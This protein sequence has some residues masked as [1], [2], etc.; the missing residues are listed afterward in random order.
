MITKSNAKPRISALSAALSFALIAHAGTVH[1]QES[2]DPTVATS[3]PDAVDLEKVEVVGSRIKRAQIEGPAPVTVISADQIEREGFTTISQVLNTLT[4]SSGIIQTEMDAG[5]FTQNANVINLRGLGPGR[6][7]VLIDGRRATDYP[8]PFDGQSNVVNLGSIPAAAVDRVELLAGGASAIYGSDAVAGVLNIVLKKHVDG[9]D[10]NAVIGGTTEGGGASKRLQLVGGKQA[11]KLDLVYAFEY[12]DRQP[13]WGFQRRVMDSFAD[14]PTLQGSVVNTR[15][16]LLLDPFDSD[17][18]G[19]I[20]I[21][22]TPEVCDRF[23]PDL[24]HSF[25]PGRGYYCGRP[26]DASQFTIRNRDRNLSGYLNANYALDNGVE[27]FGS[28]SAWNSKGSFNTG[29]PFWTDTDFDFVINAGAD[30]ALDI[31]GIGGQTVS[32]QRIFTWD[33][34]GGLGRNNQKFDETSWNLT[35]GIRGTF[36]NDRLDYEVSYSHS[37]Y[38]LTR[39]RRLFIKERVNGYF[40]GPQIGEVEGIPVYADIPYDRLFNPMTPSV[41]DSLSEIDH[42]SA[43]SSNDIVSAVVTGDLFDLPAGPL[44]FA[45]VLEWGSQEY[46]IDLDQRLIDGEFWGFTGTGGGG[47]RDRTAVGLEFRAPL[48]DSLTASIAGRYD[49]YDDITAVDDAFTYN[50]GLEWRPIESLL[51]RGSYSTSF[52]APDMHYVFSDPSGFFTTVTDEYLCRRDEPGVPLP[53]CTVPDANP[54]GQRQGNPALEEEEG[55]SWTYGMVW[56]AFEGFSLTADYYFIELKNAVDDISIANLLQTEADCRLGVTAGGQP[57]DITSGECVDALSRITRGPVNDTIFSEQIRNIVTGPINQS[58]FSTEG[59][60]LNAR[61][62]FDTRHMGRFNLELGWSHTLGEERAQFADDPIVQYRDNLQNF[63]YRS[64]IRGSIG[65]KM[66]AW[67]ATV[68]GTRYGSLPRWDETGRIGSWSKF[69]LTLSHEF[70]DDL[71]ATFI[72]NNALDKMPPRDPSFDV[73]PYFSTANYEPYGRE[74]FLQVNYKF[75]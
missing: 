11:D 22:P 25:R 27:L 39:D 56:D 45:G 14:D 4:Q 24:S 66:G 9:I 28:L 75:N 36:W 54:S 51:L 73:Y 30:P 46:R 6:V 35:G 67:A 48:L 29:T 58:Y 15:S 43:E 16:V 38:D 57:V 71:S 31:L 2:Q 64:R 74:L 55:K 17:G 53:A 1:A 21:D 12:L 8:L 10:V 61:Y 62:G 5:S 33:E 50:I 59:I 69:N 19:N 41:Y 40:Y 23:G 42:T 44:G 49:K 26:D 18:D 65:W 7:L 68:F 13:I 47:K 63:N 72:V 34:I 32:L 70:S 37:Q 3:A 52:R 60:D 20:Y